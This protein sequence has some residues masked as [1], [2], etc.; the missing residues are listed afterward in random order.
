MGDHLKTKQ[1]N[2]CYS[3]GKAKFPVPQPDG[4]FHRCR[5]THKIG[6][7][8]WIYPPLINIYNWL[9]RFTSASSFGTEVKQSRTCTCEAFKCHYCIASPSCYG[10]MIFRSW[11]SMTA[12]R[13][14]CQTTIFSPGFAA[15][16]IDLVC[17]PAA[18]LRKR[19]KKTHMSGEIFLRHRRLNSDNPSA[20]LKSGAKIINGQTENWGTL[21]IKLKRLSSWRTSV[22]P[23]LEEESKE[24]PM[25]LF[26]WKTTYLAV[27][28]K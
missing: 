9:M 7:D 28:G 10:L 1:K 6:N 24:I 8:R 2:H 12:T 11:F 23:Y 4:L 3:V 20:N 25:N 13:K 17:C 14:K 5:L 18:L 26:K 21:Q 15:N 16:R 27:K 22:A 19:K